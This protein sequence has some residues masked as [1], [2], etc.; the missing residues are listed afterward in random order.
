[1]HNAIVADP[2]DRARGKGEWGKGAVS[3]VRVQGTELPRNW[4]INA[5]CVIVKAFS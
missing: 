4:N 2:E 5:F 3:P 1:M